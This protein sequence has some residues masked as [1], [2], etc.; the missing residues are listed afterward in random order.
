[1]KKTLVI[2]TMVGVALLSCS[3]ESQ[4][5]TVNSPKAINFT[6]VAGLNTKAPISGV[7]YPK[8]VT[9]G[10]T[11]IY[12]NTNTTENTSNTEFI[13]VSEVSYNES[14]TAWKVSGISYYWPKSE[15]AS[16]DF[17]SFSPYAAAD[18]FTYKEGVTNG[19]TISKYDVDANQD[20]DIMIAD[21]KTGCTYAKDASGVTTVFRHKLAYIAGITVKT[22]KTYEGQTFTLK[23]ITLDNINYTGTYNGSAWEETSDVLTK[24]LFEGEKEFDATTTN[25]DVTSNK[26]YYVL[27]QEFVDAK[28]ITI[29]Y[30]IATGKTKETIKTSVKMSSIATD[31]TSFQENKAYTFGLSVSENEIIFT[32]TIVDWESVTYSP[33]VD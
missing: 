17:Y 3:K 23:S 22:N 24:T 13:P 26:Y 33:S 11:A 15:T 18:Y 5:F 14:E 31:F 8:D 29:T 32:P 25:V 9:F 10:T 16:L 28:T 12:Q 20:Y 4:D 7:D 6:P 1:M 27:P 30:T 19:W 21:A 2:A